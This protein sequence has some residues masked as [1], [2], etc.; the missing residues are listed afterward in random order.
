MKQ[1]STPIVEVLHG[2]RDATTGQKL[3]PEEQPARVTTMLESDAVEDGR[4]PTMLLPVRLTEERDA[5]EVAADLSTLCA[6]CKNW[7]RDSWR[8]LYATWTDP[9]HREGFKTLNRIRGEVLGRAEEFLAAMPDAPEVLDVEH[10][11]AGY[12]GVCG[13][14][15]EIEND[16]ILTWAQ[17]HCPSH[18][19][20]GHPMA[21]MFI[22]RDSD[23]RRLAVKAYDAILRKAAGR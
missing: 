6:L 21:S 23:A 9:S 18:N 14:L 1:T 10:A 15:S 19:S 12:I 4:G 8:K 5:V 7:R 20:R 16:V 11:I 3:E 22:H 13:P 2:A 17:G